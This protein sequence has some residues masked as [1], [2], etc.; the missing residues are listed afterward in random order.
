[1]IALHQQLEDQHPQ[2]EV[3]LFRRANRAGKRLTLQ[4]RRGVF[5][6][7][8]R[9]GMGHHLAAAQFLHLKRV[10]VDQGDQR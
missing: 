6:L 10:R 2:A 9:T 8:H 5:W 3:I 1:V 4:F 7:G